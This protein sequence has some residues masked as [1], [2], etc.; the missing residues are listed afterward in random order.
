MLWLWFGDKYLNQ[1]AHSSQISSPG[2]P[3][4]ASSPTTSVPRTHWS[5]QTKPKHTA[6]SVK[7]LKVLN[8]N[9]NSIVAHSNDLCNM[10]DSMNPDIIVGVET[11]IDSS[12]HLGEILPKQYLENVVRVDR[13]SGGEGIL[14]ATKDDY[15]CSAV[16]ELHTQCELAWMKMEIANCKPLY[17]CD[18]YKPNERD[19]D[20]LEQFEESL[21]RL[22]VCGGGEGGVNSYILVAGDMNFP[23]YE[24]E[25]S[26]LFSNPKLQLPYSHLP[27]N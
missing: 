25:N 19:S 27:D 13:K 11:K 5:Q 10:T 14:I 9:L 6:R 21:R 8:V 7:P 24:L 1:N 3:V 2:E 15:I 22:G 18:Y 4:D 12:I 23:G 20:S 17:I 16:T 26:C